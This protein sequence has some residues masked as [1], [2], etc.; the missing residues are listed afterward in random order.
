MQKQDPTELSKY[1]GTEEFWARIRTDPAQL[2]A[3]VCSI[4]I[5]KLDETLE[6]H[7]SL[8]AWVN[9]A[10]E[11]ARIN[12][13]RAKWEQTKAQARATI[14]IKQSKPSATVQMVEAERDLDPAIENATEH[15]FTQQ[16]IRG[17][18]HAMVS[19]L[20]D[21]RDML[22]QIAAKQRKEMQEY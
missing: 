8:R 10:F 13:A 18:L 17:G 4:N 12:E 22:I 5:A 21:R 20:E 7:A 14:T 19:A 15:L 1:L 16:E 6:R 9:A 2:A 11:V 3:E